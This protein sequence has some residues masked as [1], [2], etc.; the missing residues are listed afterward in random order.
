MRL[1][2]KE[3]IIWHRKMWRWIAEQYRAGK[4]IDVID[5]KTEFCRS[6]R[7]SVQHHCFCCEYAMQKNVLEYDYCCECPII[8]GTE[9]EKDEYFCEGRIDTISPYWKLLDGTSLGSEERISTE[10]AYKLAMEI[11]NLKAKEEKDG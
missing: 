4:M 6:R 7:L 8:W 11:A 5:L 1:T 2:K 9:K 10:E 3:A